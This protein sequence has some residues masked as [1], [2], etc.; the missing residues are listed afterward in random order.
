MTVYLQRM[1]DA[2]GPRAAIGDRHDNSFAKAS[3]H[4][5]VTHFTEEL[6]FLSEDD[7]AGSWGARS[8]HV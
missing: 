6:N 4:Q 8:F 2:Y 5:R 7:K 1:F 3:Y